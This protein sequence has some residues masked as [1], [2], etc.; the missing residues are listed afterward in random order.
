MPS[1][2]LL[3]LPNPTPMRFRGI[4]LAKAIFPPLGLM[5]VA[6][7]TPPGFEMRLVDEAVTPLDYD[8]PADLVAIST[9]TAC[10]NRAYEIAAEFRRRGAKVVI[11]GI[12]ATAE[13]EETLRSADA[14]GIGECEGYW[15]QLCQ[16]F[17]AGKL[18]QVYRCAGFPDLSDLPLP[19]RD[20]MN[21]KHYLMPRT[22]QT[23]RGCPFRCS[24]CC[25]HKFFGGRYRLRPIGQ[26]MAEIERMTTRGP[27]VFVDDN[28]F[29]DRDH[30]EELLQA[31]APRREEWFAQASSVSLQD[32]DFLQR[33]GRAGCRMV[34]V[35]IESLS[36]DNLKDINKQFNR[37]QDTKE[38]IARCHRAGIGV[39]GAFI[40]GLDG[41]EV[42]VFE[43]VVEF[44]MD[45]HLDVIQ[46]A[47]RIPIPGT[48]DS[49]VL[50]PRIFD[51]DY[52]KRD[53]SKAVFFHD[54]IYPPV[55][56][57]E[58]LQ[59]AISHLYSKKAIK[60]RL[61]GHSG[62]H[63]PWSYRVNRGF[64][65]RANKWLRRLALGSEQ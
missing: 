36:T 7:N 8:T 3:V 61:S 63:L 59:W 32:E 45:A 6:A 2:I 52:R 53:G 5:T 38:L 49:A 54:R 55:L 34:F 40:V 44:A 12:H 62:P 37:P 57:E 48:D 23:S 65:L 16:D 33:A 24:F 29:G 26:V 30:S 51:H 46:I 39:M 18:Q 13:P 22:I 11:G 27:L 4:K 28:L 31:I 43:R 20:L 21:P 64:A 35:G 14:V 56:M 9:N 42:S 58:R 15:A 41:D 1:R 25:V 47:I 50:A 10:A 17:E 19:R 60:H